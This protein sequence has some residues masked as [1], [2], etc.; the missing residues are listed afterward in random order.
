MIKNDVELHKGDYIC[1]CATDYAGY[2]YWHAFAFQIDDV[3]DNIIKCTIHVASS[4][5]FVIRYLCKP[6]ILFDTR[7]FCGYDVCVVDKDTFEQYIKDIN[8][9]DLDEFDVWEYFAPILDKA[10]ATV[11][12]YDDCRFDR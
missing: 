12:K 1:A 5:D 9:K 2:H 10:L 8:Q 11:L 3:N 7:E 6:D 4:D